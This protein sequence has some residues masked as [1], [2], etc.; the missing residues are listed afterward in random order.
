MQK[1]TIPFQKKSVVRISKKID[2]LQGTNIQTEWHSKNILII[3]TIFFGNKNEGTGKYIQL[4]SKGIA[5]I[6]MHFK[7]DFYEKWIQMLFPLNKQVFVGWAQL[8]PC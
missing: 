6:D 7:L 8:K 1:L 2:S 5:S 4:P 3:Y